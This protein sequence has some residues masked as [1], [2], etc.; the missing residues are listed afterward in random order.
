MAEVNTNPNIDYQAEY[1]KMQGELA[2]FKNANDKLSSEIAEH[3][4]KERERLSEEE[5][6]KLAQEEREKYYKDLE[7]RVALSDYA[8]EFDDYQDKKFVSEICELFADGKI[9]EA[10]SKSKELRAKERTELEK[11][12]KSDLL[13]QNPQ[14][15][16]QV[17]GGAYKTQADI[18]AI[19]DSV[20]RQKAIAE[21]P[22]LFVK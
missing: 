9:K 20:E 7:R 6:V 14:P 2:K 22:H 13:K 1:E 18:M 21:N 8:N 4:R 17:N 16:A 5:K 19:K 15:S 10:L 3:K 12:I 11:K